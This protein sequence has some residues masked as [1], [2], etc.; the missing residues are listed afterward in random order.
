MEIPDFAEE[1]AIE[2]LFYMHEEICEAMPD[3]ATAVQ[4]NSCHT[5]LT[6]SWNM[7][8]DAK[9]AETGRYLGITNG[10]FLHGE[11]PNWVYCYCKTCWQRQILSLSFV[12]PKEETKTLQQQIT[13]LQNQNTS[14]QQQF[15][16]LQ[17]QHTT[18]QQ[19][20]NNLQQQLTASQ[21]DRNN[22]QLQLNT[23]QEQLS[24]ARS[25]VDEIREKY[26]KLSN[27]SGIDKLR[28]LLKRLTSTQIDTLHAHTDLRIDTFEKAHSE[29]QLRCTT[30]F[31]QSKLKQLKSSVDAVIQLQKNKLELTKQAK[32]SV[33]QT[34]ANAAIS[35]A[36]IDASTKPLEIEI[37]QIELAIGGW[38]TF[39]TILMGVDS[40][41]L[42]V[43]LQEKASELKE[44]VCAEKIQEC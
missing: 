40:Q 22:T 21:Q 27:I 3:Y 43:P 34:L 8:T 26:E 9:Y 30:L 16:N 35:K 11:H 33:T 29:E 2:N 10:Y 36:I 20:R 12:S 6:G 41:L 18:L 15:N 14:L 13:S 19:D 38:S 37:E 7:T 31:I 4:C 1:A 42:P 5:A 28:D 23:S 39:L 44:T 17:Q 24:S 25:E 32:Q